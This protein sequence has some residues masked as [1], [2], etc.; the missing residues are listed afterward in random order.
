M[1]AISKCG[2]ADDARKLMA[3]NAEA[4]SLSELGAAFEHRHTKA[5]MG[6]ADCRR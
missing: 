3:I 4:C 5:F 6:Q 1:F 2:S